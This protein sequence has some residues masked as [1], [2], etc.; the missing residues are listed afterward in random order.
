MLKK[1]KSINGTPKRVAIYIS[2]VLVLFSCFALITRVIA[3]TSHGE[4]EYCMRFHIDDFGGFL[5]SNVTVNGEVWDT[6]D[7]H[8]YHTNNN[9]YEIVVYTGR[10]G[11]DD[12]WISTAGGL[13]DY[14]TYYAVENPNEDPN[15]DNDEY[16][17]T[18]I[19]DG[20]PYNGACYE[21]GV[22][23]VPGPFP[24][25]HYEEVSADISITIS[26][27][28][29]E[30]HYDAEHLDEA[31]VAYFKFDINGGTEDA[32]LVPFTFRNAEYTYNDGVPPRNVSSVT[33]KEPIH[34]RYTYNGTGTVEFCVNGGGTDE[35]T[36]II[37]NGVDYGDQAPH[38]KV[39]HFE[40]MM[41]WAQMF[42]IEIPYNETEYIVEV[43]GE[44]TAAENR[45]PGLGWNYL[46]ADRSEDITPETEG[47]FAHGRLEFVSATY[48]VDGNETITIDNVN[49]FNNYRYHGTGQIFQW[50]DGNKEYPEEERWRSWGEAQFPYGTTLTVR[51]VPDEGYQ[52]TSFASGP[53]G[54]QPTETPGEYTITLDDSNFPYDGYN[55]AFDLN[56]T[57]TQVGAEVR[58][59]SVNVRNGNIEVNQGVENGSL[60]LEVNDT[61]SMS[62]ERLESFEN[63]AEEAGYDINNY[64]DISLYNAIYKGGQKDENNNY[65]SWDT[66][67]NNLS[68]LARI[69]LEL[70][71]NMEGKE[72]VLI[73][74][75]RDNENYTYEVIPVNYN[76]ENNTIEFET[77]SFSD[78]AVAVR[79]ANPG[80]NPGE[81]PQPE[82]V[83]V[84]YN[85]QGGSQIESVEIDKGS[86]APRPQDPTNGDK[87]FA[88]W[89]EEEGCEHP[90]DFNN[91]VNGNITIYAKW[92][93]PENVEDYE[94]SSEGGDKVIFT[95]EKDHE[96]HLFVEDLL[97]YSKEEVMAAEGISSEEYDYVVNGLKDQTKNYGDLLSIYDIRLEN[98]NGT[99]I[100]NTPLTLKLKL[101]DKMKKYNS[102][103]L[104][105]VKEDFTVDAPI[106]LTAKDGYLEGDLK[107]LSTYVLVGDITTVPKTGDNIVVYLSLGIISILG[108]LISVF[109]IKKKQFN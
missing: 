90:Y 51:I 10:N 2:A 72:L 31:D 108:L 26:G 32:H 59:G 54:F 71:Q 99:S 64:L 16:M 89:Y 101:T 22:T 62:P 33:T 97:T 28:E 52:L 56:P 77:N 42:C 17:L 8:E 14:K 36:H 34:Y 107:H 88:G 69:T 78:Y 79:D 20:A 18:L 92:L 74:E 9:R 82:K 46:S 6:L 3:L 104:F 68:G 94:V 44:Q 106:T 55:N 81:D 41:G 105:Y 70:E 40:A 58:T 66:E 25:Y 91:E 103:K 76:S 23:L 19:M 49:D 1:I 53:N 85:T 83:T 13:D 80:E 11:E 15:V 95:D 87:V 75:R 37:I 29:L 67:I 109:L 73:H 7:D 100:D 63:K 50:N 84:E 45:I 43:T 102:F 30:Y 57:F 98:E 4:G 60:K 93:E 48:T 27:D 5:V 86:T 24:V 12:P 61:V 38:S 96:Y 65:L 47:N 21:F 39:E 35:Y